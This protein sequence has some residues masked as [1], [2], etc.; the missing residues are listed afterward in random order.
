MSSL[1]GSGSTGSSWWIILVYIGLFAV[2]YFLLIRP[3]SKKKKQEQEMRNNIAI[4]DDITTIGGIQG[5]IIAVK[6]DED[7]F[8]I[9]TG[10]D[11]TKMKFKKWAISSVDTV[12]DTPAPSKEDK[13]KALQEK[14]EAKKAA[15]QAAKEEK[16]ANKYSE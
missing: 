8:V 16:E 5:R 7:A 1:F 11:R 10:P 14:R 4:G 9:E 3:N 12:K 15:K 2:L 6:E 13:L